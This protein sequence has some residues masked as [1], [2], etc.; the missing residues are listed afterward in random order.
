MSEKTILT[1]MVLKSSPA[2]EYDRRIVILSRE[3]GKVTAFVRGARRPKSSLQAATGLFAFGTFEAYEGKNAWTVVKAEIKE[4]F[5]DISKDL[6]LTAYGCYFLEAADY[7]CAEGDDAKD[8]LNLLYVTLRALLKGKMEL[9]LIRRV[10][11]FRTLYY[12]GTYPQVFTCVS[13]GEKKQLERFDFYNHGLFCADCGKDHKGIRLEPA[14]VYALQYILS[15]PLEKLYAFRVTDHVLSQI[16]QV[17]DRI[18]QS[19]VDR[20]FNSTA[21]LP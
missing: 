7:F 19:Y 13:C 15:A 21:F 11:E 3:H 4:Y 17:I 18:F 10:Y 20:P 12:N 5:L 1:G 16:G 6:D 14:S 9:P 8:Q 2:G